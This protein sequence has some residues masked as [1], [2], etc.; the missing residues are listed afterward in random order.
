MQYV[1]KYV[2]CTCTYFIEKQYQQGFV[3]PDS[4]A[5]PKEVR[6]SRGAS[7]TPLYIYNSLERS[8]AQTALNVHW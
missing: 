4:E 5:L 3:P 2:G 1:T 7:T 6:G 8:D